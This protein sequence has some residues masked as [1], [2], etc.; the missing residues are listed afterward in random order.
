M[1]QLSPPTQPRSFKHL[2]QFPYLPHFILIS[3]LHI[4]ITAFCASHLPAYSFQSR[5]YENAR[6]QIAACNKSL[7]QSPSSTD[8]TLC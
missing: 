5:L 6:P 1:I 8:S 3:L 2:A 7:T 4:I